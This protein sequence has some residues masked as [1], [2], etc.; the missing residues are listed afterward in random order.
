MVGI[1]MRNPLNKS[2]KKEFRNNIARY[3]SIS[4]VMILMIAVVSGF[5]SVVYSAKDLLYTN[6]EECLVEDGQISFSQELNQETWDLLKKEPLKIYEN[7]YSEQNLENYTTLRIYKNRQ[8]INIVT[9][10][11]GRLPV[12]SN[13]IAL[14]RLFAEKNNYHLQDTIK[15][16]N[17]EL[18][19]VGYL[20]FPDYNSL[21]ENN[22]DLMMD[23][24]HFGVGIVNN[25]QFEQLSEG[26]I[27]YNYSYLLNN[28][29]ASDK[30]N[31]DQLNKIRDICL[32]QNQ[33]ITNMLT[34][35][36]NQTISFL[37]NDMGGDIPTIQILFIILLVILA[38]IFVVINQ[39]IIEE[40][41]TVIGTLL[42]NG[43]TKKELIRHY[44][45]I[46]MTIVVIGAIIG[47]ILGYTLIPPLFAKMYYNSY[48]LPPLKLQFILEAFLMTTLIPV[49]VM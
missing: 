22:N 29:N 26:N 14:D 44:M 10:Y 43:Y 25:E 4:I 12:S 46:P 28:Q 2:L 30:E 9:V 20:S 37:P 7:F 11:E 38:F 15:I 31:Y 27:T 35:Q 19:V 21:I 6:Q 42:A 49:I 3:L 23:P 41:S 36:M 47:N 5:L 45:I 13:E 48:C 18:K 34:K 17:Q 39:T 24:I 40:Q 32:K 33:Q 8:N 16:D 1:N